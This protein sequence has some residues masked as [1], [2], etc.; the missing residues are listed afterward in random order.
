[1]SVTNWMT[2]GCMGGEEV[3][4]DIGAVYTY[5]SVYNFVYD[6]LPTVSFFKCVDNRRLLLVWD[7][8]LNSYLAC[9]QIVRKN[10][11]LIAHGF[12]HV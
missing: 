12:V 4:F 6:F 3:I 2:L 10:C 11:N 7:K 9:V 1:M 5:N 8:E